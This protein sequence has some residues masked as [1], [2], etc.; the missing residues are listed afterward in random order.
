VVVVKVERD[1][2]VVKVKVEREVKVELVGSSFLQWN[3]SERIGFHWSQV[4]GCLFVCLSVCLSV[5][6]SV[7]CPP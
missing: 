5:F 1:V 6:L 4:L 7:C 3:S 2:K